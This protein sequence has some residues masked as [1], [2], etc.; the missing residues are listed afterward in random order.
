MKRLGSWL[1]RHRCHLSVPQT[2][3]YGERVFERISVTL[4][5]NFPFSPCTSLI[6]VHFGYL[7]VKPRLLIELFTPKASWNIVT[8]TIDR[9][10]IQ[11]LLL[12]G[13]SSSS[14]G[15]V[16]LWRCQQASSSKSSKIY[17]IV[18]ALWKRLNVSVHFF[19]LRILHPYK[20]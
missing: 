18:A 20:M 17:K 5:S 6:R 19:L 13:P 1:Y 2:Q 10:L 7:K 9:Q 15:E 14:N 3:L 11:E 4:Q 12:K 8:G 16:E